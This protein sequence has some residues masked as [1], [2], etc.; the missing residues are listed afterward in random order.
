MSTQERQEIGAVQEFFAQAPEPT[1]YCQFVGTLIADTEVI[2]FK[3][4]DE[5]IKGR[6]AVQRNGTRGADFVNIDDFQEDWHGG[7]RP[8]QLRDAKK[9]ALVVVS[10]EFRKDSSG[11]GENRRW[12]DKIRARYVRVVSDDSAVQ[13]A[14]R[15]ALAQV[16]A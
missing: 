15:E 12:F 5:L 8:S 11:Q 14:Q 4:G 7:T 16:L 6:I 13:Q 3:S 9:G 2:T 1:N 10:G